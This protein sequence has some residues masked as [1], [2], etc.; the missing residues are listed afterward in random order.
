MTFD[1]EHDQL[2]TLSE[3]VK[4]LPRTGN[5]PV[6]LSTAHRWR[7]V[8]LAGGIKLDAIRVGGVWCTTWAAFQR[9]CDRLSEAKSSP[10]PHSNPQADP[11]PAS[12]ASQKLNSGGW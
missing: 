12:A 11:T 9:F 10:S 2:I 4:K 1:F 8:G 7:T 5:R 3:L 6:H